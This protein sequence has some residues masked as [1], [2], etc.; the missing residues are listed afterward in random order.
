MNKR[1]TALVLA[2][3]LGAG[4]ATGVAACGEDRGSVEVEGGTGTGKGSTS[5]SGSGTSTS[6]GGSTAPSGTST[7]G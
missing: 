7:G 4:A 3:L 5:T 2:A 6:G 1:T